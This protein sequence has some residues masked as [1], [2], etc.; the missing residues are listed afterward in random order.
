MA[1]EPSYVALYCS[2]RRTQPGCGGL[3][4]ACPSSSLHNNSV[5]TYLCWA[6]L[7]IKGG[8]ALGGSF[9]P[10]PCQPGERP[11]VM[12]PRAYHP[13]GA[14]LKTQAQAPQSQGVVPTTQHA[15][16]VCFAP[17]QIPNECPGFRAETLLP[18]TG[19]ERCA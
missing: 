8:L 12:F 5:P 11:H 9:S 4:R 15:V 1:L 3:C 14:A 10:S 6:V 16:V 2:L 7:C 19:P 17:A 18:W 13:Y